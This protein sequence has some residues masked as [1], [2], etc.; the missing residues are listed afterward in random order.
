MPQKTPIPVPAKP[1]STY[2]TPSSMWTGNGAPSGLLPHAV[3]APFAFQAVPRFTQCPPPPPDLKEPSRAKLVYGLTLP[4]ASETPTVVQEAAEVMLEVHGV[5]EELMDPALLLVYELTVHACRFTGAGELVQVVIRRDGD[6]FQVTAHDTHAPHAHRR[7]AAACD[8][9][10][11]GSLSDVRE[12]SER[13]HGEWG[14]GTAYPPAAG[15][16]TWAT[17]VHTPHSSPDAEVSQGRAD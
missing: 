15:V 16:C 11:R 12:L 10:R 13:H 7:L 8:E 14:F 4:S 2:G 17:L 3:V 9:R 1:V 6:A 5:E